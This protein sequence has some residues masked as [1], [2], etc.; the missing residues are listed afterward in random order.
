MNRFL[1]LSLLALC[2]AACTP[3]HTLFEGGRSEYSIVIGKLYCQEAPGIRIR[4]NCVLDVRTNPV[5]SA[6]MRNNFVRIPSPD[7]KGKWITLEC[8]V[9]DVKEGPQALWFTFSGDRGGW[10]RPVE[11]FELDWFRF[12]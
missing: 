8:D 6:R 4:D 9:H 11:L 2:V 3:K 7:G 5:F 1:F 10:Q 12:E